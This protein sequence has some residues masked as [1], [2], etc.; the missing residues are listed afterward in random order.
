MAKIIRHQ[1]EKSIF[2]V[3]IKDERETTRAYEVLMAFLSD[4]G[5][6]GKVEDLSICQVNQLLPTA[7]RWWEIVEN[8]VRDFGDESDAKS[9]EDEKD[10]HVRQLD[11]VAIVL[12][13]GLHF[14]QDEQELESAC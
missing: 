2:E 12:E 10:L 8:L 5:V 6:V 13:A 7:I 11:V 3:V 14:I 9:Y 1:I 4:F